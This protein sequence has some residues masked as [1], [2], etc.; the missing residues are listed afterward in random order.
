MFRFAKL[1]DKSIIVFDDLE[2]LLPH[3]TSITSMV[4]CRLSTLFFDTIRNFQLNNIHCV[5]IGIVNQVQ[6]SS[7]SLNP[8]ICCSDII[9]SVVVIPKLD[10][11]R[12]LAILHH[13]LASFISE[14]DLDQIAD[15]TA[16]YSAADLNAFCSFCLQNQDIDLILEKVNQQHASIIRQFSTIKPLPG[17][18]KALVGMEKIKQSIIENVTSPLLHWEHYS[19][20]NLQP[21][22][23]CLFYGPS[24][25]GKTAAVQAIAYE[26]RNRV[27]VIEVT[28]TDLLSKVP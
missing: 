19:N 1:N 10:K 26:L 23:G 2:I 17:G 11:K 14:N 28:C 5:V 15:E 12:R 6:L 20:L 8:A 18:F 25:C 21:P 22:S 9:R 27:E 24:G 13:A 4:Q 16:S 3:D 7:F